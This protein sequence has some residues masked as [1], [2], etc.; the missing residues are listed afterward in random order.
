MIHL[1]IRLEG[2]NV[3]DSMFCSEQDFSVPKSVL[4]YEFN[5]DI[6]SNFKLKFQLHL[7]YDF[8]CSTGW[9]VGFTI[10]QYT[11]HI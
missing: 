7:T 8:N 6:T 9:D 11:K 3:T 1:N 2:M 5:K 10:V 4:R